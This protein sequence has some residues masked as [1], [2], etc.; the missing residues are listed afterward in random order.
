[1]KLRKLEKKDAP[2]ML[3]WMH[4][5]S[6][7]ENMQV[8]FAHKTI[9]DC[10][11]F[12]EAAQDTTVNMHLAIVND[13][14][15]YMGTVSLK[16]IDAES[17]E[18]AITIRKEAMGKDYSRCGMAEIIRIGF[19]DLKLTRIYWC[20][21]PENIRACKFYDKNGYKQMKITENE[22]YH[23]ITCGGGTAQN[24][25]TITG[26]IRLQKNNKWICNSPVY[27]GGCIA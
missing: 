24:R 19:D 26:G 16:N 20:V 11:T 2:L 22:K 3:E 8:D 23:L 10:Y 7:V 17:A 1:M 4:D 25:S 12:I 18:F 9:K 15:E 27:E 6:V 13:S 5:P 14:D 21:S